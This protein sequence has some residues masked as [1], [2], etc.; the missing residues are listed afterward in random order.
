[1][2]ES[3]LRRTFSMSFG[4][5]EGFEQE[6]TTHDIAE[7]VELLQRWIAHRLE[8]G[9]PHLNGQLAPIVLAYGW[10]GDDNKAETRSEPGVRFWGFVSV[11]SHPHLSDEEVE[12]MLDELAAR[13][14][15]AFGQRRM[16]LEY[17]DKTWVLELDAPLSRAD[18]P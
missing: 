1:M 3:N 5:R 14:A 18:Q 4:L 2:A 7:A 10:M 16:N 12:A 6:A 13:F 8:T 9:R 17:R 11:R 15:Q